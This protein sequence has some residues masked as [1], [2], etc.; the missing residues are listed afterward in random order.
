MG[1][2]LWNVG[3]PKLVA[4]AACVVEACCSAIAH[5]SLRLASCMLM[6]E[7]SCMSYA[8]DL[9]FACGMFSSCM[10]IVQQLHKVSGRCAPACGSSAVAK[11]SHMDSLSQAVT[12]SC[13]VAGAAP[14]E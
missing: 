5:F 10:W 11:Y 9:R 8:Q 13:H 4:C 6:L 2:N 7:A 1:L 12:V 3:V 14:P